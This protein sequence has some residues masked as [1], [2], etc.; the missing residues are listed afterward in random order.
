VSIFQGTK[1][2]HYMDDGIAIRVDGSCGPDISGKQM[3][4][5]WQMEIIITLSR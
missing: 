3:S 5:G 1:D 4:W 2:S